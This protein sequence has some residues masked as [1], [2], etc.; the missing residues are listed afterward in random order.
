ML[1]SPLYVNWMDRRSLSINKFFKPITLSSSRA[2]RSSAT[3]DKGLLDDVFNL[4]SDFCC[5]V[6]DST[7]IIVLLNHLFDSLALHNLV[8]L[9]GYDVNSRGYDDLSASLLVCLVNRGDIE[10][11]EI[12][13]P[14]QSITVEE[15]AV[16]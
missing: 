7:A 9:L 11:E 13:N 14:V 6:V 15:V 12:P 3:N 4:A 16:E 1:L 10:D 5:I 2:S 8:S